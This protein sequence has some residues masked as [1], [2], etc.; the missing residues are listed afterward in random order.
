LMMPPPGIL[1]IAAFTDAS[2]AG[3]QV[4]FRESRC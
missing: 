2:V 1:P 3:A 4:L